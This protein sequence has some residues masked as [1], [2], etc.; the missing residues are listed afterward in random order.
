M[1][2][3]PDGAGARPEFPGVD[4]AKLVKICLVHDLGEA[5]GGDVPAP[6]QARRQAA[7]VPPAK[8]E[9]ERRDLLTLLE[10]LPPPLKAEIPALWDEYE[11]APSRPRRGWPR[12]WTSWRPSCSTPRGR[13]R[14]PSTTDSTWSTGGATPP[15]SR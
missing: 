12:R 1:A 13:T 6:E 10:P 5:V 8:G 11:A 9:D 15:M 4:F 3:V 2:P 7:G 14:P